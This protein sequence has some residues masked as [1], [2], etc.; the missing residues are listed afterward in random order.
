MCLLKKLSQAPALNSLSLN[1]VL[2]QPLPSRMLSLLHSPLSHRLLRL[3][4]LFLSPVNPTLPRDTC[5]LLK[6]NFGRPLGTLPRFPTIAI[7]L[8]NLFE[9]KTLGFVDEEVHET[10][11]QEASGE[12]NEEDFA[13]KVRVAIA[14]VDEVGG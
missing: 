7:H 12:P 9:G 4:T 11:A 1:L 2:L 6:A 14:I 10:N 3:M 8:V 13:L 5:S